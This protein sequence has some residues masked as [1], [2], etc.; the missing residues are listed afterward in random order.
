MSAGSLPTPARTGAF[1]RLPA[2]I[3]HLAWWIRWQTRTG[4]ARV[5]VPQGARRLPE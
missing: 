2:L 1:S 5:E 3:C 4:R